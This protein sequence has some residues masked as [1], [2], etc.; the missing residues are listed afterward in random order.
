MDESELRAKIQRQADLLSKRKERELGLKAEREQLRASVRDLTARAVAAEAEVELLRN[1][2]QPDLFGRQRFALRRWTHRLLHRRVWRYPMRLGVLKHHEPRP[3][4]PDPVPVRE[5]SQWPKISLVTPSYN[6]A[7][8]LL[9][10]LW[11]VW[12]Q[13]YPAL[14]YIVQDGGSR[15]GSVQILE[16][17]AVKLTRWVSEPDAGLGDA[18]QK[19][20]QVCSGE[21]M[22]WLNSDDLLMP[23][24]LKRVAIYFAEHPEVDVVYG[25]RIL[26]DEDGKQVG[27][28]TL[29]RHD[30]ELNQWVDYIPQETLFWRRS[31]Y[32]KVGGI[33]GSFRFAVDWDLILRLQKAGAVFRRMPY[34]MGCF[35][36]HEQQK[37]QA[38]QSSVGSEECGRLRQREL[39]QRFSE[40]VLQLKVVRFQAKAILYD[41]LL[42]LGLRY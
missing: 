30:T 16:Q 14:E 39:G 31:V 22:G 41:L 7:S 9:H 35:R 40:S 8:F 6:Q 11:S 5:L 19:A 3:L 27:H 15:D 1:G 33:D 18:L 20:F 36:V 17:H 42:R 29:P 13:D 4:K 38:E 26:V 21:I 34:F 2:F 12:Q 25:H 23:G 37:S 32:E 28:W 24:T 10:T